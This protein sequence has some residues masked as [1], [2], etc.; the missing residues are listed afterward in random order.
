[1]KTVT[2]P[3]RVSA[4]PDDDTDELRSEIIRAAG[5]LIAQL[6]AK[7]DVLRAQLDSLHREITA[8]GQFAAAATD[9][10]FGTA[11]DQVVDPAATPIQQSIEKMRATNA[12]YRAMLPD[13]TLPERIAENLGIEKPNGFHADP[14]TDQP[15]TAEAVTWAPI[16]PD[17]LVAG[18]PATVESA[19][20]PYGKPPR[21]QNPAMAELNPDGR[22]VDVQAAKPTDA[23]LRETAI[24]KVLEELAPSIQESLR[25]DCDLRGI[26][27]IGDLVDLVTGTGREAMAIDELVG[28]PT[29]VKYFTQQLQQY[30]LRAGFSA[31]NVTSDGLPKA[32]MA[33]ETTEEGDGIIAASMPWQPKPPLPVVTPKPP[34]PKKEPTIKAT[35]KRTS[36]KPPTWPPA[37]LAANR[38]VLSW[39]GGACFTPRDASKGWTAQVIQ[40]IVRLVEGENRHGE[41]TIVCLDCHRA[42]HASVTA[43]PMCMSHSKEFRN[44]WVY[45]TKPPKPQPTP[46]PIPTADLSGLAASGQSWKPADLLEALDSE[47]PV[48]KSVKEHGCDDD[49]LIIKVAEVFGDE[50]L[51]NFGDAWSVAIGKRKGPQYWS[52]AAGNK[53]KST[54]TLSGPSLLTAVRAV[55][56]IPAPKQ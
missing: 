29:E 12:A 51:D 11:G 14:P 46:P 50:T 40:E 45:E 53:N 30:F 23:E 42:R 24:S 41:D 37:E 17:D 9:S 54:A 43:C 5:K 21:G 3:R 48:W 55:L 26:E 20:K 8:L 32:W 16:E 52:S 31:V 18:G 4:M 56:Q 10:R 2:E 34:K 6:T 19:R 47:G 33:E 39:G 38:L 7:A 27:N 28:I 1:M 49:E 25:E 22:T 44:I 15:V 13:P 36:S 35:A